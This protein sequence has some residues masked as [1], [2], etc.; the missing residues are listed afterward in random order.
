MGW[1]ESGTRGCSGWTRY[2]DFLAG[3]VDVGVETEPLVGCDGRR[4]GGCTS[5]VCERESG[6]EDQ[7]EGGGGEHFG[8]GEI[9]R[10]AL[11]L[12]INDHHDGRRRPVATRDLPVNDDGVVSTIGLPLNFAFVS[13]RLPISRTLDG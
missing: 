9:V 5:R 7:G 6:Y 4:Q 8:E 11:A 3:L 2:T 12:L 1:S 13:D 10:R